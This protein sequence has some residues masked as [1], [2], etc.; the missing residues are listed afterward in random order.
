VLATESLGEATRPAKALVRRMLLIGL[1][2]AT[3][4]V[5]LAY[6][7]AAAVMRRLRE[8]SAF[9]ARVAGGDLT[10]RVATDGSPELRELRGNLNDMVDNLRHLSAEVRGGAHSVGTAATEILA[11]VSEQGSSLT[12]QSA[13]IS[14]TS[15][16]AEELRA[17]AEHTAGRARDVADQAQAAAQASHEGTEVVDG[18]VG[19]ME[20]IRE[21]SRRSPRT[22]SPF[23]SRPSRSARSRQPST[24]W[25]SSPICWP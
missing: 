24:T 14:Q 20:E 15:A 6:L 7:I 25:P 1:V 19:G 10:A 18:I 23:P 17:A 4:M 3:G 16:T 12:E 11:T 9:T 8:Y 21:G 22:S 13:A 2:I 5:V